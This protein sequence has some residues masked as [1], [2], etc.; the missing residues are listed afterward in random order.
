MQLKS[1]LIVGAGPMGRVAFAYARDIGFDVK[2]FLD[3]RLG[4]LDGFDGY[5]PILSSLEDY[6]PQPDDRFVVA[7]GEPDLKMKY[8]DKVLA[9]GGRFASLI[10]PQAYVGMNVE[11]GEGTIVAPHASL[12]NDVK[13]GRHVLIG[14]NA[15]IS[16][17]SRIGDYVSV[18][19]GCR[20]TGGCFVGA[21]SFL[22]VQSAVIPHCELG[23]EAPVFVAAGA[24]VTKS[25]PSGR[26]MG[27]PAVRK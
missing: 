6:V 15:V 26:L 24:I 2:G 23:T 12:T 27:V 25:F 22:G 1:L 21:G 5:P 3:S 7:L 10:H 20:V 16:H 14:L 18:S 17:D 11:I 19:P 13:I 9:K 8:V 4:A